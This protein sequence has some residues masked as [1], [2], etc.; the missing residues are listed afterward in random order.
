MP[1][2]HFIALIIGT[3]LLT[4]DAYLF[5]ALNV[6]TLW[7]FFVGSFFIYLRISQIF[8]LKEEKV[9]AERKLQFEEKRKMEFD[10]LV[11]IHTDKKD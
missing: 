11:A 6:V 8:K 5:N 4:N 2:I 7:G 9:K 10:K 3:L 1:S